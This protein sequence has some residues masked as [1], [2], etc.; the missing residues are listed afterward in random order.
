MPI[1][2]L[3][4]TLVHRVFRREFHDIPV[5]IAAVSAG[6]TAR[7]KVVADH[8]NFMVDAL[9]HHHAAEDELAWPT[10]LAR[11]PSRQAEI[12]RTEEQHRGIAA[13]INR[14]Q[15]DLSAWTE[16]ADRSAR[17]R[18]LASV[19]ELSQLLVQHLDDEERNADHRGVPHP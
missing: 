10:L 19:A 2:A 11:T 4:M 7:V 1:D 14:L 13:A 6:D 16:T 12:Q 17:D 18:L 3:D 15:S 9:H 5:M 8:L